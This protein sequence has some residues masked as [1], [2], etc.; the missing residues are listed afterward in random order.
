MEEF[1]NSVFSGLT[2]SLISF[3]ANKVLQYL[4]RKKPY[5]GRKRK[6]KRKKKRKR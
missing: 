2:V 1:I 5:K 3:C 6:R 4:S